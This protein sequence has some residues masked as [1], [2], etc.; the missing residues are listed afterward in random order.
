MIVDK[1]WGKVHT[2]ALNQPASVR[3]LTIEPGQETSEHYHQLREETWIVLDEH[4]TVQIGNRVVEARPGQEFIVGAE[5]THRIV[6]H[7]ERRGRV[8]EVAFGYTTEDDT[9]RL[10]DEYGRPLGTPVV[11]APLCDR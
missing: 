8:L 2:Y 3:L 11:M 7:G 4:L 6:N 5:E 9:F 10:E 1:P